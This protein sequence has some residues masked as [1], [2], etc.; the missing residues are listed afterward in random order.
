MDDHVITISPNGTR[1]FPLSF[2]IE[3]VRRWD[4][5]IEHGSKVKLMREYNLAQ[6]TIARWLKARDEGQWTASMVTAAEKSSNRM[7][8]IDRAELLRLRR[9]NEAL[10]AKVTQAEAAQ[11]ILGKAFE[12]L[13]GITTSSSTTDP[14]IPPALMTAN[15][16]ADWLKRHKL[17]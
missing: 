12:L 7:V 13:E 5:A 15:E 3:F 14:P 17:S 11:Q 16:Y 2:R 10:K 9:E 4:A 1:R 6:T 8:K